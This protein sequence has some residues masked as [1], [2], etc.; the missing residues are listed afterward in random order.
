MVSGLMTSPWDH[1]RIFSGTRETQSDGVEII[2]GLGLLEE[3][4]DLA[5]ART[6]HN[7]TPSLLV[8]L[9]HQLDIEAERL[10]LSNQ[11]VE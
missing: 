7:P 9:L 5:Q 6:L 10:Q 3:A 4:A 1:E 8:V 11:Y 2:E